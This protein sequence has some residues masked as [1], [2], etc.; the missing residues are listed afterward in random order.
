MSIRD[1]HSL[2]R[3]SEICATVMDR[4]IHGF[5]R[6]TS[7][8]N[9]KNCFHRQMC[10]DRI[11]FY[12]ITVLNKD[13]KIYKI[14]TNSLFSLYLFRKQKAAGIIEKI[15]Y[16]S[17]R[18][19]YV[20]RYCCLNFIPQFLVALSHAMPIMYVACTWDKKRNESFLSLFFPKNCKNEGNYVVSTYRVN[21]QMTETSRFVFVKNPE[22]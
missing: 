20:H 7:A 5:S 2:L 18:F 13:K 11:V 3:P 4:S 9:R 10:D 1:D 12:P 8:R 15:M 14:K 16:G 21:S 17:R 22:Q 6:S 19:N